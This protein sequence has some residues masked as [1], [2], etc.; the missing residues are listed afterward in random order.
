MGRETGPIN[1]VARRLSFSILETNKEFSKGK[2][3]RYR[4]GMHGLKRTRRPSAYG[5]QLIEKQKLR[6]LYQIS[7][8][9]LKNLY[10]RMD[11]KTG[12]TSLQI[13]IALEKRLDNAIF[14][15]GFVTTRR[16]ARQLVNHGHVLVNGK[17]IDIPSYEI[18]INDEISL[19]D[20]AKKFAF[21]KEAIERDFEVVSYVT[22][23]TEKFSG[24]FIRDPERDELTSEINEA[25]IVEYYNRLL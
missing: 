3:R 8:T 9:Q 15:L 19:S 18:N 6:H 12:V 13:L 5:K 16:Q 20:K 1:K 22:R 23:D 25:L 14:R 4:P 10:T 17:K 2:M 11:K 7:E 21:V 24:K